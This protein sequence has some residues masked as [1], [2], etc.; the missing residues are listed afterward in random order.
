M[1]GWMD[2]AVPV[3][4][5]GGQSAWMSDAVPMKAESQW[6]DMGKNIIP[7][8]TELLKGSADTA[9]RIGKGINDF[10]MDAT[11]TAIQEL[12]GVSPMETP[13]GHD[14]KTIGGGIADTVTGIPGAVADL[15]SKD[16]WVNRPVSNA[17]TVGSVVSPF[18]APEEGAGEG[19]AKSLRNKGA[20]M[21]ADLESVTGNTISKI[22]PDMM[23]NPENVR[24]SGGKPNPA[25]LRTETGARLIKEG[26]VGGMG[27][28]AGDRWQNTAAKHQ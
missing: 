28:D 17:L 4:N 27:Q 2:D 22:K 7:N 24:T 19:L 1:S 23:L 15:A 26:V 21:A 6:S 25:D 10:P 3:S 12:H 8:A 9:M 13:I 5:T 16:A 18:L 20:N 14:I 11:K